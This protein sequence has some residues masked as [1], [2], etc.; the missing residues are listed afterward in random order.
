M[1]GMSDRSGT[2]L[3]VVVVD[4]HAMVRSGVRAELAAD[5]GIDVVGEADDVP[6]AVDVVHAAVPDV[7]LLDVHLPGGAARPGGR[8][9]LQRCAGLLGDRG[10]T[11]PGGGPVRFLA[12]SVSDAA[13][14][15]IAVIRAGARG[16]VP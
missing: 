1:S 12:L 7:V 16:Y 15:V 9:V 2:R 13:E 6:S 14:D 10:A 11:G 4:D 8:E 3:R 5:A